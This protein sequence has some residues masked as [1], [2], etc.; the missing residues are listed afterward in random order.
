[1]NNFGRVLPK[2]EA[3]IALARMSAMEKYGLKVRLKLAD[4]H[5]PQCVR[6]DQTEPEVA[7][8]RPGRFVPNA[9]ITK[10]LINTMVIFVYY[11]IWALSWV[12][13]IFTG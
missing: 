6:S 13:L 5:C 10:R 12:T 11:F 2:A 4:H 1:M 8:Q 7:A 3:Q 9:V